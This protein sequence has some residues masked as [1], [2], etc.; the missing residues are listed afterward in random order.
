S[1]RRY[2]ALTQQKSSLPL[3]ALG[4]L[5]VPSGRYA[6]FARHA[7]A[8]GWMVRRAMTMQPVRIAPSILSDEFARCGEEVA[9]VERAGDDWIHVDVMDGR[10]VP[11]I[12][13]GPPVVRAIRRAT[14]L[15]VD[16]HLMIVEPEKYIAD[17]A[18]AGA[19][20]ISIQ[21]EA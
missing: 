15:P 6:R 8:G 10:F 12:T 5:A 17:F 7:S 19:D 18:S 2:V 3:G 11:N 4:A 14:K 13:L 1:L 21:A 9:A 20:V 16:C